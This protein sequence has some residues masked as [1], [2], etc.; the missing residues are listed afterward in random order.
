M[1]FSVP[2]QY[3]IYTF[4]YRKETRASSRLVPKFRN[5]TLRNW[6]EPRNCRGTD[7]ELQSSVPTQY[8]SSETVLCEKTEP[9]QPPE[10]RLGTPVIS[11]H[12][13]PQFRNC[14]LRKEGTTVLPKYR[15]GTLVTSTR[16][17][18]AAPNKQLL[19]V[20]ETCLDPYHRL[21]ARRRLSEMHCG[22]WEPG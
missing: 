2:Q 17:T 13:V 8:R 14:T 22:L 21:P 6:G 5:C 16:A 11:T 15:L 18:A 10:N 7:W 3:R 12:S 9:R 4:E 19:C 20:M 1:D